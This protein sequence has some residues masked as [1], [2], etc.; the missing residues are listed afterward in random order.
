MGSWLAFSDF[1]LDCR[2]SVSREFEN[3]KKRIDKKDNCLIDNDY[4]G[5]WK[6]FIVS[7]ARFSRHL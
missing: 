1:F 5:S 3:K 4:G 2:L 6:V 7:H